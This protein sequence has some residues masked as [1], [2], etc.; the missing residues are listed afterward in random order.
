MPKKID[1]EALILFAHGARDARWAEP[2]VRIAERVRAAAPNRRIELAYLE[3]L[4]PG[5]GEA[6]RALAAQ[7]V[8]TIRVIPLFFGRGGHL[9]DAVPKLIEATARSMPGVRLVLGEAAGED[10]GVIEAVAAFC[11]RA[12]G[13]MPAPANAKPL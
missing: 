5:L 1:E 12:A 2:F 9:R 3:F 10:P 7:G 13:E 8:T 6:V 4:A 11:L